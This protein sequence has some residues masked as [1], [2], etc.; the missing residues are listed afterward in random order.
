[1][2]YFRWGDEEHLASLHLTGDHVTCTETSYF[3]QVEMKGRELEA[4]P[5]SLWAMEGSLVLLWMHYKV[6]AG[7]QEKKKDIKFEKIILYS[8]V[9]IEW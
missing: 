3:L 5:P 4:V 7:F 9:E 6:I 8:F 2:S 1:M